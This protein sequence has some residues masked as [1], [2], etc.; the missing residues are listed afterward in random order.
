M[1]LQVPATALRALA[2][3]V[4]ALGDWTTV[5]ADLARQLDRDTDGADPC[6]ADADPALPRCGAAP[7]PG[8]S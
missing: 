7:L 3:N 1:E 2:A 8:D 6:T 5:V 4:T